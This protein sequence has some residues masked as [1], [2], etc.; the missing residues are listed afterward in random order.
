[1]VKNGFTLIELIFA[2]VV[3][4]ISVVSL[5]MMNQTNTKSLDSNLV[6]EAIF[7][8]SAELNGASTALW[9]EHSLA[10]GQH[11]LSRVIDTNDDDCDSH[12]HKKIGHILQTLHRRCLN[13]SSIDPLNDT[14]DDNIYALE[15]M[16]H[17]EESVSD[18]DTSASGYKK[19]YNSTIEIVHNADFNGSN[20]EIKMIKLTIS[21]TSSNTIT[22]LKSFSTNIGEVDYYKRM[23]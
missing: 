7:I 10:D 16:E 5:P 2:I 14:E 17:N 19:K 22:V 8:A 18:D 13:D 4:G 6:Q 9:D 23:Y 3:I 15:D 1:M 11:T 20:Q 12:T 21:D